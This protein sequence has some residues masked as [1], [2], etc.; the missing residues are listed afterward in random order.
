MTAV[1]AIADWSQKQEA[2]VPQDSDNQSQ[3]ALASQTGDQPKPEPNHQ[4]KPRPVAPVSKPSKPKNSART[5]GKD[6]I[7]GAKI[8]A[9]Y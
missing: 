4:S 2:P 9:C 3:S 6:S 8:E 1:S 5:G 7:A